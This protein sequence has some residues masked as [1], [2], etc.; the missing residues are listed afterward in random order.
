MADNDSDAASSSSSSSNAS[1][2]S[3]E[4]EVEAILDVRRRQTGVTQYLIK[5]SH[6]SHVSNGIKSL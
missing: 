2:S 5:V 4:F 3:D 6:K 1:R